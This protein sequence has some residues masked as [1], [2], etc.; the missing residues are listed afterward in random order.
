[1]VV[2]LLMGGLLRDWALRSGMFGSLRLDTELLCLAMRMDWQ[3]E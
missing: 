3:W 2:L 1:M